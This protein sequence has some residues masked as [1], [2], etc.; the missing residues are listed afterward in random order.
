MRYLVA[1]KPV[2]TMS[3]MSDI[4][5]MMD[6]FFKDVPQWETRQPRTD[7]V[8]ED[9]KY[10]LTTELP[11]IDENHLDL[12]V[13]ENLLT[14]STNEEK[15][16]GK[17]EVKYLLRERT[18]ATFKRSF[19]LPKDVDTESITALFSN[20]ILTLTMKVSE[21]AKPRTISISSK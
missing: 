13:E 5:R 6:S 20:G 2:R 16:V 19:V 1:N 4:D 12:K 3:L 18:S 14:I 21:K 8:K 11:G 17:E 10:V 7:I 9:D 15:E